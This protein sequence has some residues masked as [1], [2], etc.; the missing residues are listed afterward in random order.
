MHLLTLPS[1][2]F[3]AQSS[4]VW[5]RQLSAQTSPSSPLI[6]LK[7]GLGSGCVGG[8][9]DMLGGG[10]VSLRLTSLRLPLAEIIFLFCW[11]A[12]VL[13][14]PRMWAPAVFLSFF[15]TAQCAATAQFRAWLKHC[16][17]GH[18]CDQVSEPQERVNKTPSDSQETPIFLP[19][20]KNLSQQSKKAGGL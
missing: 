11:V 2:M 13:V 16:R 8:C 15:T 4:H 3:Y 19:W 10:S 14:S 7:C 1:R 12:Y 20:S 5:Q 17:K 18:T 9:V 6:I